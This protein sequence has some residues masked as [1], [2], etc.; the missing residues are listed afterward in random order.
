MPYKKHNLQPNLFAV[1]AIS[2]MKNTTF[3]ANRQLDGNGDEVI[4]TLEPKIKSEYINAYIP[5][6]FFDGE[7]SS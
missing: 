6:T 7:Q 3:E 4:N 2:R 5:F 1:Y